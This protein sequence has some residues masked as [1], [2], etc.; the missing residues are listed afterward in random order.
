MWPRVSKVIVA[1]SAMPGRGLADAL[2]GRL[3]LGEVGHRLDP[4]EVDAAGDQRGGLLAEDVDRLVVGERPERLDDLAGRPDVAGDERVTA[5]RV[6]L[7]AEQDRRGPV[8]LV[9]AVGVA[10]QAGAAPGSRRTCW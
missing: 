6:D 9:D 2:D 10:A 7:G 5:G 1:T 3:D 4:D 8:Q